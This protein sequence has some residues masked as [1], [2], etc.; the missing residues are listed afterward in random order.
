MPRQGRTRE[1]FRPNT[2]QFRGIAVHAAPGDPACAK[3]ARRI[4][5]Y[6]FGYEAG[7][8]SEARIR[9]AAEDTPDIAI[10]KVGTAIVYWTR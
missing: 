1:R 8:Q 6:A 2:T 4:P 10:D 5:N 9:R 7:R 3:N